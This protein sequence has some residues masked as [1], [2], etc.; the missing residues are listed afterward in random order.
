[1][2]GGG[3]VAPGFPPVPNVTSTSRVASWST[4]A[5]TKALRTGEIPD[6]RILDPK[7]MPWTMSKAFTDVEIQALHLYLKSI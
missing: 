3:P 2:Q 4:E 1:M 6:G 7:N 5:F